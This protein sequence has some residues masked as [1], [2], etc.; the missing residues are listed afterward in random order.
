MSDKR[1]QAKSQSF[2][3]A[4]ATTTGGPDPDP[5]PDAEL[6]GQTR[7]G[8][9][10]L[11]GLRTDEGSILHHP[12]LIKAGPLVLCV[13]VAATWLPMLV[14]AAAA[15]TPLTTRAEGVKLPF[16]HDLNVAFMFFVTLPLVVW[17]LLRDQSM[18]IDALR[19]VQREETLSVEHSVARALV[20]RWNAIFKRINTQA[21]V[22]PV[23][24][25]LGVAWL[26]HRVYSPPE[27]GHWMSLGGSA[28]AAGW[29]FLVCMGFFYAVTAVYVLRS[30]A[31]WR[32][33]HGLARV[34]TVRPLPLH[35]S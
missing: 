32:F 4:S 22:L 35:R 15:G 14:L 21:L 33:L 2:V 16:L 12:K 18:L 29:W 1:M 30:L 6:Q 20:T 34:G 8:R 9:W 10:P 13:T 24:L 26:N 5:G 3:A 27:L 25:G 7:R 11:L 23:M 19:T 17:M 28:T 31:I